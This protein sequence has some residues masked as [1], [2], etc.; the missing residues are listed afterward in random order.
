[1][2]SL[3]LFSC[4]QTKDRTIHDTIAWKLFASES[5]KAQMI[6]ARWSVTEKGKSVDKYVLYTREPDMAR[7][8]VVGK[9][10][11]VWNGTGGIWIDHT[12][13]I[14]MPLVS[15]PDFGE[16]VFFEFSSLRKQKWNVCTYNLKESTIESNGRKLNTVSVTNHLVDAMT[17]YTYTFDAASK[18]LA[19]MRVEYKGMWSG[20]EKDFLY[21]VE[22]LD[23]YAMN[24]RGLFG[25]TPPAGYT[26]IGK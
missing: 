10:V 12:K 19:S 15:K 17:V 22:R 24:D 21:S 26:G 1:M 2:V 23:L 11:T 8:D 9:S 6:E 16:A 7:L 20:G 25:L 18:L 13:R 14:Y 5:A 4:A 3:V